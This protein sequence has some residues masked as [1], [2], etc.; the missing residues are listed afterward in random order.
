MKKLQFLWVTVFILLGC[1]SLSDPQTY[2]QSLSQT[3]Q[4]AI[5]A[6]NV[7]TEFT[8]QKDLEEEAFAKMEQ[9]RRQ[10]FDQISALRDKI[11][12]VNELGDDKGLRAA[13]LSDFDLMLDLLLHEEKEL[14]VLWESSTLHSPTQTEIDREGELLRSIE[15]KNR[16][17]YAQIETAEKAYKAQYQIE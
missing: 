14:I 16:A 17:S 2:Y 3:H 9:K 15:E 6:Y 5:D 12:I 4:Q 1:T 10:T 11:K 8:D 7:Y 13:Y